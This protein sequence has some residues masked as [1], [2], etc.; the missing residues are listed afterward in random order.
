M[1]VLTPDVY[2]NEKRFLSTGAGKDDTEQRVRLLRE[3]AALRNQQT[4]CNVAACFAL[5]AALRCLR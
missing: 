4:W 1:P 5:C 2:M 3:E